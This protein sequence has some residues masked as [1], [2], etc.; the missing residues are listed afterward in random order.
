MMEEREGGQKDRRTERINNGKKR[1]TDLELAPTVDNDRAGARSL[2]LSSHQTKMK[3]HLIV[4]CRSDDGGLI[5]LM[6]LCF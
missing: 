5:K 2:T 3:N 6:N 1:Q 4:T